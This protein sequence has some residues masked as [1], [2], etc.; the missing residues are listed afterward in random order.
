MNRTITFLLCVLLSATMQAQQKNN[1]KFDTYEW[2][3]GTI[4]AADGALCHTF[5]LRNQ[6]KSAVSIGKDIPSCECI[7]AFYPTTS[8]QPGGT[9][10]VMV[11]F[12]PIAQRGKTYRSIELLDGNGKTLGALS[13][14][15]MVNDA[16]APFGPDHA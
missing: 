11:V 5:T 8:I 7:K 14:K 12:S 10:E 3:F 2:D 16:S 1:V 9:A 15:A 4:Q 6:T 13:I